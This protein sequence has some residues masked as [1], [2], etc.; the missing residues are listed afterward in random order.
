MKYKII[1]QRN[2]FIEFYNEKDSIVYKIQLIGDPHLGKNI[3]NGVPRDRL[4]DREILMFNKFDELLNTNSDISVVLG[5]LFDKTTISNEALNKTINLIKKAVISN[6]KKLYYIINGNHDVVR[7][8][9][10]VSSFDMLIKYFSESMRF[11]N[12]KI[13]NNYMDP[14]YIKNI[15]SLLYFCSYNPFQ[16]VDQYME[17]N[18][19]RIRNIL[20][21]DK[22]IFKIAFGHFEVEAFD[23]EN[24]KYKSDLIPKFI[25]ENFDILFTG[26]IHTPSRSK[27]DN[28]QVVVSGSMQPYAHGEEIKEDNNLYQTV[29]LNR[30]MEHLEANKT[31]FKD[32]NVRILYNRNDVFP[33]P[34][35]CLSLTYKLLND[36]N[37]NNINGFKTDKNLESLSFNKMVLDTFNKYKDIDADFISTI[38]N[39]FINRDYN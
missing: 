38:E 10:R 33:E 12:L 29:T 11:E 3:K 26:H 31:Y 2:P 5:D 22:N 1:G 9:G 37:T 39:C 34:F 28:L 16:T 6:P 36:S 19:N 17:T 13:I 30:C 32:K 21:L 24:P 35:D 7:D 4:G 25:K 27:I 18:G 8:K 14:V 15:N 23:I 20:N